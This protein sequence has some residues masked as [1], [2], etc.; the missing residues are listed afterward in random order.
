MRELFVQMIL[1]AYKNLGYKKGDFKK[2]EFICDHI[3]S[4]PIC[5]YLP[6]EV[7]YQVIKSINLILKDDILFE[8]N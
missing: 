7:V 5:D 2:A 4:L 1:L 6:K 8:L 3:V